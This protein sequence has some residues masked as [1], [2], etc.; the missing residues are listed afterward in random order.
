MN[1]KKPLFL[2]L[3]VPFSLIPMLAISK[4]Q[5]ISFP[6][7]GI[8]AKIQG[9]ITGREDEICYL[10]GARRGQ[11]MKVEIKG[12]GPTAGNIKFPS[13]E[14]EGQPGGV[15][16]DDPLKETGDYRICVEESRMTDPWKGKFILSVEIK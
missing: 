7:G 4:D 8:A 3:L 11:Q 14:G 13:G 5:R 1:L 10:A 15:I 9:R 6:K 2:A 16:F 12:D